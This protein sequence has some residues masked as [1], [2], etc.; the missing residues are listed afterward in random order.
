M[1]QLDQQR[2]RIQDDLR[3]L[4]AGEVRCDDVFRRLWASDASIYEIQPLGVVRPRSTVDV[5]SCVRYAA[6]RN[7]SIHARGAGTGVAGESLGAG[8]VLDFST[9]FH[10]IIRIDPGCVRV[11]PGVVY[12]RLNAQLRK[13]GCVFGPDPAARNVTTL[14]SMIS[15]DAA[16][17]RWLKYGSTRRH[18][19]SLQVVL[20]DGAVLELGREPLVD[21]QST[22]T[23]P[24][25]RDLVDRL[26]AVLRQRAELINQHRPRSPQDHCGYH[27]EG[28][29]TDTHLDVVRLLV[30]SEGTLA[31]VT[32]A[33]LATQPLPLC[34]G[35]AL[36]LLDSVEKAARAVLDILPHRPVACDLVDRRHLSLCRAADARFERLIPAET[37]A[38]LLV[39]VDG[40]DPTEV[41]ERLH[42]L[43]EE[44]WQQKHVIFGAR[45]AFAGRIGTLHRRDDG[46]R[47]EDEQVELFWRLIDKVQPMLYRVA[48]SGRAVPV[49]EDMAVSPELLPDFL[50]RMQNVL[51]RNQV[52]ASLYCHAGQGQLHVQPFLDLDAPED[53]QR[54]RQLADELYQEVFAVGGSISGE[55]ACGLSRTAYVRRQVGP[56]FDVFVEIKKI[57]D[58]QNILNPGKI[59]GD[60]PEAMLAH[61]RPPIGAPL[62]ASDAEEPPAVESSLASAATSPPAENASDPVADGS[63]V[64]EATDEGT[65]AL[66]N[67]VEL[68]LDWE[69]SRVSDAV[70]ACNRCGECRT[71]ASDSRM[72]PIFRFLPGEEASPR[73]K[74]NLVR[75]LLTGT[76]DLSMVTSDEFKAVADL[77][78][79]CHSCRLECPAGV[80]IPR[81]MRECKGAYVAA[82]SRSL[83]DWAMTRLDLLGAVGGLIAPAANWATTNRQ[84]RWLL[85]KTLGIAKGRKLP[86]VASRSF[87]RWAARHRLTR[88]SRRGAQKVLYFVDVYANYFDPQLGAATVAVLEHN[89]ISVYVPQD[90]K[91]AGMASIASG[92]LD[93]ARRLAAHN[94]ALLAEAVRQGYH[95]VATEPAAALCLRHE[96]LQLIDD[97]D[98]RLVSAN[99]SDA[100]SFLWKMHTLGQL[101]L[102][103]RPLNLTVGYH[104][105]CHLRALQVGSPGE[106]LL[107][108]IPG[109]RLHRLEA[110]CSGMA[111]TFGLQR[112]HFRSSLRAG[113]RLMARLRDP[114]LQAGATECSACKMQMEQGT[115]KSTLHPMKLLALSYGLMPQVAKLLTAH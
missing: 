11:Q 110:G 26:A 27:L 93:H 46:Q 29:L 69:P 92:A 31:L 62:S 21:G 90:Q 1:S 86:R 64:A 111:G 53:V 72:C 97:D 102:D 74:A 33:T 70:E 36:L 25:K 45:Q 38:V 12:G 61:L 109:L 42:R 73:A 106:N 48:G 65:P 51:K 22:S 63:S 112:T 59:L 76:L 19:Q 34:R 94:V 3:G 7:I 84:M 8:L 6:E 52:T 98:A 41:R 30:G 100:G 54:M 15:V 2:Q 103:L 81:L 5:A 16:G 49:V 35:V 77:C 10:R 108:L 50:V 4:V 91:Q 13:M 32:E 67:L 40:D 37:E 39:E 60:D 24:Q 56:L 9:H 115:T 75:G 57:F 114:D 99:S 43:I 85:E 68:Q 17:S 88:P 80:D 89:G 87:V 71:Q 66:R 47:Q 79:H 101:Q 20:A 18:V 96:Y 82:N 14:G 78:V 28:V 44:M 113:R 55:H 58:P 95:I 107:G 83:G 104:M 23:I 105:P